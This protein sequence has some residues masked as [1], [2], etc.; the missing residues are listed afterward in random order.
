MMEASE[1]EGKQEARPNTS[2]FHLETN[3]SR[4][5]QEHV[6]QMDK[7]LKCL[8]PLINSMRL[9]GLYFTRKPRIHCES[10]VD[11]SARRCGDWNFAQILATIILVVTWL[12]AF[13]IAAIFDGTETLGA[14]L[15]FKLGTITFAFLSIVL[16]T[17]YYFASHMGCLN[18]VF[19]RLNLSMVDHLYQKYDRRTK[20][21]VVVI[22][23]W[24][25][26]NV[27]ITSNKRNILRIVGV[28]TSQR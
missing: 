13:R 4:G 21:V 8:S 26:W 12:N 28:W 9:F 1:I 17:S 18:R 2:V 5:N 24:L 19:R 27:S 7:V 20:A 15:F 6:M 10:A 3:D 25:F 11:Q 22:W 16:Q 14:V 23:I